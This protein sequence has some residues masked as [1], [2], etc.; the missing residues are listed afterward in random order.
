[1]A[2]VEAKTPCV[3]F[4]VDEPNA[5]VFHDGEQHVI[6][7]TLISRLEFTTPA[8]LLIDCPTERELPPQLWDVPHGI[9][10]VIAASPTTW[11][12]AQLQQSLT[13]VFYTL[14]LVKKDEFK[15]M[16]CVLVR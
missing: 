1:M 12:Y 14:C 8:L 7:P 5:S 9:H 15:D 16:M 6:D 13:Y 4:R 10:V 11:P 2:A 3:F